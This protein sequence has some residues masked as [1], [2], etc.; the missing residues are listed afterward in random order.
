[1]AWASHL[2]TTY[3]ANISSSEESISIYLR[4]DASLDNDFTLKHLSDFCLNI[5][6][7]FVN[8]T[9]KDKGT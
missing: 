2:F 8:Q 3:D 6:K 7:E 1:M 4:S 5:R 9:N